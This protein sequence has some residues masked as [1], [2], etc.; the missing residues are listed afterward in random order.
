MQQATA[1]PSRL[2][3]R[4]PTRHTSFYVRMTVALSCTVF[5]G[6]WFTYFGPI[7]RGEYPQAALIIHLH[8]WSF[9]LWYLLLPLQAGLIRTRRVSLH[10]AVGL[11]STVLATVMISVGLI[12]STVRVDMSL[13]PNGDPFWSLMGVPIFSIWVLFA[14]FYVAAVHYR[15]RAAE[16]KRLILL[17]SAVAMSA[18]TFRV[19]VRVFGFEQWVAIV[20]TLAPNLFMLA[21]M[22]YDYRC[23]GKIHRVYRWGV[24]AM[25]GIV[26]GAFLL[27]LT[28]RGEG[29]KQAV[30][31]I[32]RLLRPF[33]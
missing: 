22:I 31:W 33:Y 13:G 4:E 32:G 25:L 16:H 24:P 14:V 9:F 29:V 27:V 30:A 2:P 6:F 3:L 15:R 5:L 21:A 7:L 19:F 12:V 18:A 1:I 11:A 20:G 17:A 23:V 10:R 26:G 28:P 8:G